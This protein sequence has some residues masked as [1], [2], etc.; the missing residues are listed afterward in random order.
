MIAAIAGRFAM[1]VLVVWMAASVNFLIPRLADRNPVAERLAQVAAQ[2]GSLSGIDEMVKSYEARFGL[3]R[4]LWQQYLGYLGDLARFDLG[5][6]IFNY[7]M[8]VADQIALALPWTIGLLGTATLVAFAVGSILGALAGWRRGPALARL[9]LPAF[10]V[11]SAIPFYL[12]GLVFVYVFA[13][14]LEWFPTG[15]GYTLG[16]E[17]TLT[18]GFVLDL[19][20]HALL[21]A[22]SIV[23]ASIGFWALAMRSMMVTIEGEDYVLFAEA[24]GLKGWRLF[25]TYGVRNAL[26]PQVTTLALALGKVVTGA[27]LVEMVFGYP[28]LGNLLFESVKLND[29]FTIYGCVIVL[30]LTVA[31]TML[32]LDLIVPLLDPRARRRAS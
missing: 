4:P 8:R 14:R 10:M 1:L 7:P 18:V 19:V 5:Y 26:L 30:V 17:P 15:G 2:G 22:F 20:G 24:K 11:L 32:L 21:P 13:Y 6:S 25:W 31:V 23:I 28:G 12:V 9:V 3:D 29:Y 16:S 27:V